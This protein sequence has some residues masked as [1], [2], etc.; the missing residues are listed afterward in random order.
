MVDVAGG[1]HVGLAIE[2]THG[3][4]AVPAVF[5]P[6]ISETLTETRNDPIR[7]PIL[8]RAVNS[9][10]VSGRSSAEGE[11]VIEALPTTM[12]YFLAASRWAIT[13]AGVGP[14]TYTAQDGSDAHVKGDNRSLTIAIDRAGVG[15][16]YLGC[17]VVSQ[18]LFFEDGVPMMAYGIIGLSQ[19]NDYTPGAV[20]VP[21]ETPFAAD[22][23]ALTIAASARADIDSFEI[24]L[25]DNGEAKFNLSGQDGADYV[26]FGEFD[27][28]ASFELDFDDKADYAIWLA[29]TAQEV[30]VV[31]TKGASQILDIELH[32][33]TYDSF[34]VGLSAIGDQ[35]RA[36]AE[37]IASFAVGDSAAAQIELT[38][39]ID[40]TE[41][42]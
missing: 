4:Y 25:E 39:A 1:G 41:I 9:G 37:V 29:L 36:S 11:I 40:I 19:T 31:C 23:I 3:T 22:E 30:K 35:V 15:F 17:Q 2:T 16:A 38:S 34:E 10:K 8:G 24:T 26:K 20:T 5:A 27:G 42:V 14:Y 21:T 6:I 7:R 18:R 13:K 33:A 32:G 28:R 12:A